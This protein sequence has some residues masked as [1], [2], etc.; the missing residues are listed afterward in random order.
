LFSSKVKGINLLFYWV[1]QAVNPVKLNKGMFYLLFYIEN[2][3]NKQGRGNV[4]LFAVA[5][6]AKLDLRF[7]K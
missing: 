4:T 6:D 5:Q 3:T 1:I 2:F 7:D